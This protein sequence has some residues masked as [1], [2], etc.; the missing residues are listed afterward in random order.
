MIQAQRV[1]TSRDR[2]RR[3]RRLKDRTSRV[4]SAK[5]QKLRDSAISDDQWRPLT[6]PKLSLL[7]PVAWATGTTLTQ[8]TFYQATIRRGQLSTSRP[9][10]V[11]DRKPFLVRGRTPL[12]AV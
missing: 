7:M 9:K 11:D 12:L 5:Q 4:I 10:A 2:R 8:I 1:M 3:K 6:E